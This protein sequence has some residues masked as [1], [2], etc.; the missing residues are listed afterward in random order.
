MVDVLDQSEVDA[1]LAAVNDV[2]EQP[3]VINGEPGGAAPAVSPPKSFTVYD[4][5]RPERVSK[6]QM[7]AIEG[8]HEAFAR[9]FGASMSAFLRSIVEV[10]ITDTEQLTYNEFLHSLPNPTCFNLLS[11]L[12]WDGSICLE[13]SPMIIFPL[14]DRLL[15]GA[16]DEMFIPQR[17]LTTIEQRL[18][19]RIIDRA[20]KLLTDSWTSLGTTEMKLTQSESNPH[21][22]QV[23]APNEVVVVITFELKLT[24]KS[25]TMGLCI[26]FT[27]IEPVLDKLATQN[28]LSYRKKDSAKDH[29][30]HIA[31]SI[32][33][34]SVNLR[35]LLAETTISM[36]QLMNLQIGDV[37]QTEKLAKDELMIQ[38]EGKNKFVGR[39]GQFRG[40]R[41]IR[42]TRNATPDD[43]I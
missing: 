9:N 19:G 31:E 38:I 32:K 18:V 3:Q 10:K 16:T 33:G 21:L 13:I 39:L 14:L 41:S 20:L 22:V 5:K 28:W 30:A 42:I 24:G 35:A 7:R 11:V 40:N 34:A 25:G 23:V 2:A 36:G 6:D 1:L 17:P 37:I 43:R 8:I 29:K 4:F 15:G 26:P 12:P 27:T